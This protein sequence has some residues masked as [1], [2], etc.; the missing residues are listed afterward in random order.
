MAQFF[1]GLK[2]APAE[3][4]NPPGIAGGILHY[5]MAGDVATLYFTLK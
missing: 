4:K 1:F 5:G 3:K 2:E